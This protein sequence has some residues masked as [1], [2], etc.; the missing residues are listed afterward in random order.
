MSLKYDCNLDTIY[1]LSFGYMNML[2]KKVD[3]KKRVN[4][5]EYK[6]FLCIEM[7]QFFSI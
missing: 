1:N 6:A 3:I 5:S 4:I 2:A 7:N